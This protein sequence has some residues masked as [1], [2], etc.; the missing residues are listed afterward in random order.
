MFLR[1]LAAVMIAFAAAM[2]LYGAS[3]QSAEETANVLLREYEAATRWIGDEP[4]E[5]A[6]VRALE[7]F[8]SS[9]RNRL[10]G[11]LGGRPPVEDD[12]AKAGASMQRSSIGRGLVAGLLLALYRLSVAAEW[13]IAL[14]PLGVAAL[15]DGLMERQRNAG[16]VQGF[17]AGAYGFSSGA[18]VAVVL[19][20]LAAAFYYRF[21]S[22]AVFGAAVVAVYTMAGRAAAHYVKH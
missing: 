12:F 1:A 10:P 17:S 2:W 4:A 19:G 7:W 11:E 18:C 14:L 5:A 21:L 6:Y 3:D 15:L 9:G 22:P 8:D 13:A 16:M 20:A